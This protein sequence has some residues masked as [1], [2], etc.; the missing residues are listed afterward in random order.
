[1]YERA[2]IVWTRMLNYD[3][4]WPTFREGI[5]VKIF[6]SQVASVSNVSFFIHFRCKVGIRTYISWVLVR[7]VMSTK[8]DCLYSLRISIGRKLICLIASIFIFQSLLRVFD[9]LCNFPVVRRRWQYFV[10]MSNYVLTNGKY[11]LPSW[12]GGV[13]LIV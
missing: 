10:A 9:D 8:K 12:G 13:R 3:I 11:Y 5:S 4:R 1:M 6:N 2:V 7:V